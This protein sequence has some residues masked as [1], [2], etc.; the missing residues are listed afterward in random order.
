MHA[1]RTLI[2]PER[3]RPVVF[4]TKNPQS[5]KTFLVDGAVAGRWRVERTGSRAR[6]L[7][8]PFERL[9]VSAG[10]ELAE[11]AAR[12]VRFMEPDAVSYAV[13]AAPAA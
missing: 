8:E 13:R 12:L 4:N 11:E 3:Y 10:T 2:L 5:L 1:R 7:L 6:V 9:P